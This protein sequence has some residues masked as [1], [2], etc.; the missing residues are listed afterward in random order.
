MKPFK[1]KKK[2]RRNDSLKKDAGK[3]Y[4]YFKKLS[5]ENSVEYKRI[6]IIDNRIY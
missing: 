1:K 6:I 5:I 3:Q 4:I 2:Q